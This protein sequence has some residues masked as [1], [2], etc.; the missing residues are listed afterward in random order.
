MIHALVWSLVVL[1]LALWSL[2]AWALHAVAVW[3]VSNAGVLS[4]AATDAGGITLPAWLAPWVPA[5]LV[6]AITQT[7][8]GLGPLIDSL[9]QALPMLAGALTVV[10]WGIWA[11]GVFVLLLLGLAGHVVVTLWR[12]RGADGAGPGVAAGRMAG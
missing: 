3:T 12:R 11:M 7:I 9:L 2:T 1:F 8:A 6:Q 5:D 10:A 4:G